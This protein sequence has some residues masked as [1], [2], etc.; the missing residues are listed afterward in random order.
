MQFAHYGI[1]DIC[2]SDNGPQFGSEL[3]REFS[4]KWDF[5]HVTL[6]PRHSQS[7]G[8]A[9]S[10][11]KTAKQLMKKAKKAER[12]PYLAILEFRNTPTKD[13]ERVQLNS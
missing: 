7:N 5:Q 13:S 11:V 4:A 9:E 6:S 12:D 10:A 1:P 8:K 2:V 3:F